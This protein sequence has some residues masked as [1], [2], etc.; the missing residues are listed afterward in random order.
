MYASGILTK[1]MR[2]FSFCILTFLCL[3]F[4]FVNRSIDVVKSI[5]YIL[6][7]DLYGSM[8]FSY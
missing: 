3:F 5:V 7:L 6:F 4:C 1:R 2:Y 8:R